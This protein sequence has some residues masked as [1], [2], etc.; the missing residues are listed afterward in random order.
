MLLPSIDKGV[1]LQVLTT[2]VT[3]RFRFYS[4]SNHNVSKFIHIKQY[5]LM[6]NIHRK[7]IYKQYAYIQTDIVQW[8]TKHV[9]NIL[10][11]SGEYTYR[12]LYQK[13]ITN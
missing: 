13:K 11:R 6:S 10:V 8:F 4:G 3:A 9:N 5:M 2:L 1:G 12:D 7:S